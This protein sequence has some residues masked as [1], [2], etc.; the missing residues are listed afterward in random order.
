[1][2]DS[3]SYSPLSKLWR[4]TLAVILAI[5][6]APSVA[7]A[8][9]TPSGSSIAEQVVAANERVLSEYN[10]TGNINALIDHDTYNYPA[11][12]PMPLANTNLPEKLD[13]R[14]RGVVTPVKLQNPWGTCWAF[15]ATAASETSILSELGLTYADYNLDLS[16]RHLA[17]MAKT[18]LSD[19]SSQDGEGVHSSSLDPTIVMNH[20]GAPFEATSVYSSGIGPVSEEKVP[21]RNDEGYKDPNG[22]IYSTSGTWAVD[23]SLRFEQMYQLEESSILP[24]PANNGPGVEAIKKELNAGRAVEAVYA[25]DEYIP[26]QPGT[27]KYMNADNNI[28][29]HYSYDD[30]A[31]GNHAV[32]I[33]GY[34]D[35]YSKD[36]FLP[37]HQP[38]A[39]G[40]WIVKNSW[41]SVD[42]DIPNHNTW[43]I[44]GKGYFMLSYCDK[45]V[46]IA[47][48]FNYN[49]SDAHPEFEYW[50]VNQYDYLPTTEVH[51]LVFDKPSSVA[52]VFTAPERM[53][54]TAV[55]CETATPGTTATYE[56]YVLN[57]GASIPSDGVQVANF[58]KTY[59]YGGYH[60]EEL[61]QPFLIDEGQRYSVVVTLQV[62]GNYEVLMPQG[63]SKQGTDLINKLRPP[64]QQISYYCVGIVN[65]GESFT[66]QD[67]VW[68]DWTKDIGEIYEGGGTNLLYT[69]D[70]FAIKAFGDP[71]PLPKAVVPDLSGMTEADALAALKS[72]NLKGSAGEAEYSDTVQPGCVIRQDIAAGTQVEEGSAVTYILSLGKKAVPGGGDGDRTQKTALAKTGDS[73]I[74]MAALAGVGLVAVGAMALA[75][76]RRRRQ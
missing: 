16:E 63:Y 62:A 64:D 51:K 48:T 1:M 25:A 46:K 49:V 54:V 5:A 29:A 44:D 8:D 34:D 7:F 3:H 14:E 70:N 52:N 37:G 43:G 20:G 17:W 75:T 4:L 71:A 74:P 61:S 12:A 67:N 55:S 76:R 68:E 21:Y 57:E 11:N 60:R 42:Q 65:E 18:P 66:F 19:G 31:Y 32:C 23:Q 58:Q 26:G 73:A 28:W 56:I 33:V 10:A 40:A 36:N 45:S 50:L 27:P 53:N 69:Y 9:D 41:G 59:E 39:D 38:P 13:L 24:P 6:L 35:T 22:K 72:V 2:E 15:G 30:D 47:E